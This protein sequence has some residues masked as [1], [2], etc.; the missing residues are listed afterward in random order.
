MQRK[1]SPRFPALRTPHLAHSLLLRH[2]E[3]PY[4]AFAAAHL[5]ATC[6][7][8]PRPLAVKADEDHPFGRFDLVDRLEVRRIPQAHAPMQSRGGDELAVRRPI[9]RIQLRGSWIGDFD[10][11]T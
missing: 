4:A 3:D 7:E 8:Q 11:L 2:R 10:Q 5:R 6:E 9:D 1:T